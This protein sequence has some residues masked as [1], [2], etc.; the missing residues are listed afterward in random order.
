MTGSHAGTAPPVVASAPNASCA[1]PSAWSIE[2]GGTWHSAQ[3]IGFESAPPGRCC[4]CAP[5]ASAVVSVSPFVPTGG[6]AFCAEPWHEVH[7]SG[8]TSSA[9]FTWVARFTVVAV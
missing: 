6:A 5:T 3:A 4:W 2:V 8:A 7:E 1:A 9:P